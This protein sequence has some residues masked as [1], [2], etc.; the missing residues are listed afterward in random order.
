MGSGLTL[1]VTCWENPEVRFT[2]SSNREE[3]LSGTPWSQRPQAPPPPEVQSVR[4]EDLVQVFFMQDSTV[5][6]RVLQGATKNRR[7]IHIQGKEGVR[8][9]GFFFFSFFF[10]FFLSLRCVPLLLLLL[11]NSRNGITA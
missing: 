4:E 9:S 3:P 1:R 5:S 8:F 11:S 2:K 6:G 7:P 10:F